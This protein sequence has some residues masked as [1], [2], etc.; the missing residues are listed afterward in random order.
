MNGVKGMNGSQAIVNTLLAG[1]VDVCFANPGTSEMH[2]VAALD[3][4]TD[5]RCVLGLFE[6]VATGAADGYYRM[7]GKPAATLLHLGPGLGN[8]L[9]N[10]HNA[11]KAR[12]GIVN[13]IG[14]HALDHIHL[15][16]PLNS[17]IEGVARP[18]SN[19]VRTIASSTHA[20]I[21]T[22]EAIAQA[23]SSPGRIA[24]LILPANCA[25]E[26]ADAGSYGFE[27]ACPPAAVLTQSVDQ[28]AALLMTPA[29][30]KRTVLLLGGG[31]LMAQHT[32]LAG[33]IAA[34]TGCQLL[35]EPRSP[36]LQRGRGRVNVRP[37]PYGV[38]A[39]VSAL[40]NADHIVLIGSTVPVAFFA[41]PG[42]PR[43]TIPSGCA[44]HT[45]ATP[46]HDLLATLEAL[47]EATN[48]QH[49]TPA[50]LSTNLP[51]PSYSD[52]FPTPATIGAVLAR[53]LPENAIL[54]DEAITS[55]REL[56]ASVPYFAPHDCLDITGGAIG[57][58]L[59]AAVGA[60][61]AA[62]GRRVVA[63]VGDGSAM[64]T[65]QALWT[66]AREALDVTI[67]IFDNRSYRILRG[68]LAN[69]GAPAPGANAS[70]MLDLEDPQLDWVSMARAHGVAGVAIDTLSGFEQALKRANDTPGPSLIALRI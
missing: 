14:Q 22:A 13:V 58:G 64:Y 43:L 30:A 56:S 32:Q 66:M 40:K 68:E 53:A 45:L 47:R 41:Y 28:V 49:A 46:G 69:M 37:I 23:K 52:G 5:M 20:A 9:A 25:W 6:G 18:M 1:D 42:K 2:F 44:V 27:P 51:V 62:P 55:G 65:I 63:L 17:D 3:Q 38:D 36:R 70:R 10:L 50:F 54:V 39:A 31:A 29:L 67:V 8:G 16:A 48:S 35:S 15:D 4:A 12:S 60:A 61:I 34:N 57:F 19:W 7:A 59:P 21:D 26:E 33:Q 11:R 24:S